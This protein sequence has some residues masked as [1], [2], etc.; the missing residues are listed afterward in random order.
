V[1]A[2]RR[3]VVGQHRARLAADHRD[4]FGVG[5]AYHV[6]DGGGLVLLGWPQRDGRISRH[7]VCSGKDRKKPADF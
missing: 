4:P 2:Q 5:G 7:R 3:L 6:S 1:F